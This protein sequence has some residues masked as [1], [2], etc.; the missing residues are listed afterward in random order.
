MPGRFGTTRSRETVYFSLVSPLDENPDPNYKPY[1]HVKNHHDMLFVIDLEAAQ[2]SL[3]FYQTTN[4]SVLC[5]D[6]VPA[7]FPH[8]DHQHQR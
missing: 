1:L 3:D 7:E 4:G 8:Q 2:H 5:Y 6:T